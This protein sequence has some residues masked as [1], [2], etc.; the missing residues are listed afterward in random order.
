MKKNFTKKVVS[1]LL[2]AAMTLSL[3]GCGKTSDSASKQDTVIRTAVDF[4]SLSTIGILFGIEK[5]FFAEEGITFEQVELKD[6][7][8][9]ISLFASGDLDFMP[10][11]TSVALVGAVNNVP[12]KFVASAYATQVNRT[13]F[14]KNGTYSS[15][16]ELS[17]KT[18]GVSELASGMQISASEILEQN[19]VDPVNDANLVA[20]G[21]GSAAIA[22]LESDQVDAALLLEPYATYARQSGLYTEIAE[23]REYMPQFHTSVLAVSDSLIKDNPDAVRRLLRA[24]FKTYIYAKDNLEEYYDFAS[25]KLDLDR[26]TVVGAITAQIDAWKND[27]DIKEAD[28]QKTQEYQQKW[29]LQEEIYETSKFIDLSFLPDV[30]ELKKELGK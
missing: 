10:I 8:S 19:G 2:A 4:G 22:S 16:A 17:G 13:L 5:G 11:N 1:V 26:D 28:L 27:P 12:Y 18:I 20:N 14:V 21:F 6:H 9:A 29:G 3:A 30:E 23:A 15:P 25:E 7:V 24:Y